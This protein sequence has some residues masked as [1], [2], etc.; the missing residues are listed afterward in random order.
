MAEETVAEASVIKRGAGYAKG[1]PVR[2]HINLQTRLLDRE[3]SHNKTDAAL[4]FTLSALSWYLFTAKGINS[5]LHKMDR[6][7]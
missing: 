7:S 2:A 3:T 6:R 4:N 1:L 5:P